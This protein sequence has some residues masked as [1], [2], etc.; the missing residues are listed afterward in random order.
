MERPA[1]LRSERPPKLRSKASW[2]S[3]LVNIR[4]GLVDDG[5]AI[6]REIGRMANRQGCREIIR[7][8]I[9]FQKPVYILLSPHL[10]EELLL[11]QSGHI[12]KGAISRLLRHIIGNGLLLK[13]GELHAQQRRLL[14]PLFQQKKMPEYFAMLLSRSEAMADNWKTGDTIA[15]NQAM[16]EFALAAVSDAIIGSEVTCEEI[17]RT[18]E[19]LS[20]VLQ[21]SRY[22]FLRPLLYLPFPPILRIGRNIKRLRRIVAAIMER[23]SRSLAGIGEDGNSAAKQELQPNLLS[24]LIETAKERNGSQL[25]ARER[26]QICEELITFFLAGHETTANTLSWAIYLLARHPEKQRLVQQELDQ[27]LQGRRLRFA[28]LSKL[29]Y[30]QLVLTETL[31]L[32][33]PAYMIDRRTKAPILLGRYRIPKGVDLLIPIYLLHRDPASHQNPEQFLP[34]RFQL[35]SSK[36]AESADKKGGEV[37]A[38]NLSAGEIS[39][40]GRSS[41]AAYMPFGLGNRKCIGERFAWY[42]SLL[43]L[44]VICSRWKLELLS[45]QSVPYQG[46]ITLR[47]KTDIHV[48][49]ERRPQESSQPLQEPQ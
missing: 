6:L 36:E 8:D 44:A 33:P 10:V 5:L 42:E 45:G 20:E 48:R 2:L 11:Q 16:T 14:L 41:K 12:G 35:P 21:I 32:Y 34:E 39:A 46:R 38:G 23:Y 7:M 17:I 1:F 29:T 4:S 28:D 27:A 15:V 49:I 22:A 19:A 3:A 9:P 43:A 26:R 47:P 37:S 30:L 40:G 31:R 25:P 24:L 18:R 13:E